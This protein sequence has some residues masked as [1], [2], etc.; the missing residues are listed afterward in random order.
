MLHSLNAL[1]VI[2]EFWVIHFHMSGY[3]GQSSMTLDILAHDLISFFFVLSGCVAVLAYEGD[4]WDFYM[5]RLRRTYPIYILFVTVTLI[6]VFDRHEFGGTCKG[7]YWSCIAGDFLLLSP[8]MFCSTVT[9]T[10]GPAWY[11]STLFWLWLAFPVLHRYALKTVTGVFPIIILYILSLLPFTLGIFMPSLVNAGCMHNNLGRLPVFRLAEFTMGMGVGG[12]LLSDPKQNPRLEWIYPLY[13]LYLALDHS[14]TDNYTS[15]CRL[16]RSGGPC[17][18][19]E[20]TD[21]VQSCVPPW[22]FFLSKTSLYWAMVIYHSGCLEISN[23]LNTHPSLSFLTWATWKHMSSFSV[24]A[25]LAHLPIGKIMQLISPDIQLNLLMLSGYL[26]AY[27]IHMWIQP[28]LDALGAFL[29]PAFPA[30]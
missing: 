21:P 16:L 18:I 12:L 9:T 19:W 4:Y 13:P 10:P 30:S 7:M 26:G 1:R 5:R 23:A 6:C 3:V 17:M 20:D 28:W 14:F 8:W 24:Q 15:T 25:Y 29:F 2:A 11:I 22:H 27:W